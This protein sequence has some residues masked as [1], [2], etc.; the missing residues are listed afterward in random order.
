MG[1]NVLQQRRRCE[2]RC[3]KRYDQKR[4]G[5]YAGPSETSVFW[6]GKSRPEGDHE[7]A[8]VA[9]VDKVDGSRCFAPESGLI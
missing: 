7:S 9:Q 6:A 1:E 2:R 3:Q 4:I 8:S 5:W